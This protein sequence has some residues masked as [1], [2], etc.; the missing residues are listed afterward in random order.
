MHGKKQMRVQIDN[1][2]DCNFKILSNF[3]NFF[4]P[5]FQNFNMYPLN[6]E[7]CNSSD[8]SRFI[9]FKKKKMSVH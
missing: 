6:Y 4:L 8:L 5:K 1:T 9:H 7:L 3:D 2:Q